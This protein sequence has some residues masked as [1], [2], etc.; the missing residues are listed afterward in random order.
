LKLEYKDG[1][2]YTTIKI[3]CHGKTVEVDNVVVDTGASFCI[4]EPSSVEALEITLT[5]DDE[6]ETFYGVNG[7]F[8][9]VK[10]TAQSIILA[11]DLGILLSICVRF[12]SSTISFNMVCI[13]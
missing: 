7:I 1:L 11:E 2:L 12:P 4:I 10:R 13:M 3:S 9:Y 6:I 8:G 5:K